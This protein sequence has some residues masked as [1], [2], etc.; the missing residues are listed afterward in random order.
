MA[1]KAA[2]MQV[3]IAIMQCHAPCAAAVAHRASCSSMLASCQQQFGSDIMPGMGSMV[4]WCVC[5]C[6]CA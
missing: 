4:P 3:R 6:L 1:E 2:I 5:L